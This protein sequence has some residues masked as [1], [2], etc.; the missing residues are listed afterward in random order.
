VK[1]GSDVRV[2]VV[3]DDRMIGEAIRAT[4][5]D[6]GHSVDWLRNGLDA[7][8]RLSAE[9]YDAVLLDLGLPGQDGIDVLREHRLCGGDTPVLVMTARD[10]LEDR[11][12]GLDLG[13]DD[14]LVKPFDVRELLAR[15]RAVVR[16]RGTG[17]R[18]ASGGIELDPDTHEVFRDGE[19]IHLTARE[20]SLLEALLSRPGAILSRSQIESRLYG[21]DE[22]V[23]SNAVDFLIHALR[24]KLGEAA[25]RNVRGMGWTVERDA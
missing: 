7:E 13:A 24:R 21:S 15:L 6:A 9:R 11:I 23:E 3:E 2:L 14:Y 20:F 19:L 10:G 8:D 1:E 16:R 12:Q 18:L 4:L 25:I 5:E 17:R 22:R